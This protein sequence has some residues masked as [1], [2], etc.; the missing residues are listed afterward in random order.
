MIRYCFCALVLVAC[1]GAQNATVNGKAVSQAELDAILKLAPAE[2]QPVLTR[3]PAELLRYYGLVDRLAEIGEKAKLAEESPTKEQIALAR[4]QILATAAS[5]RYFID[6]PLKPEDEQRFYDE[7]KDEYTSA[8]VKALCV[9]TANASAVSTV[10]KQLGMGAD[11]D[12]LAEK[13]PVAG[14]SNVIKKSDKEVPAE[15]RNAVFA[16]KPGA[17]TA[18]ITLP[19]GA[20]I[21]KLQTISVKPIGDVR[22]DIAQRLS[23]ERFLAWLAEVRQTVTVEPAP[24]Q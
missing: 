4:K 21:I 11:F 9:P 14:F 17:V 19:S 6:H 22:G 20:Y 8:L 23:T 15:V 7:H 16:L 3:D 1:A 5:D 18:P 2:L 12:E 10:V 24:K 13:Y